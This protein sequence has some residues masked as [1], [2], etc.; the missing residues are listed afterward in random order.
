MLSYT[1][2]TLNSCKAMMVPR[3]SLCKALHIFCVTF[4]NIM[5][6]QQHLVLVLLLD[7]TTIYVQKLLLLL[8]TTLL[9]LRASKTCNIHTK[10]HYITIYTQKSILIHQQ[11]RNGNCL[12]LTDPSSPPFRASDASKEDEPILDNTEASIGI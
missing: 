12:L 5:E 10:A 6:S 8:H 1:M 2:M 4:C 7:A 9:L 3:L 11:L